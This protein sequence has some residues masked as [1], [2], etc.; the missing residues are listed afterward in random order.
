MTLG[1]SDD[2]VFEVEDEVFEVEDEEFEDFTVK[3]H[4]DEDCF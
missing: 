1:S 4:E 2:E 3:E